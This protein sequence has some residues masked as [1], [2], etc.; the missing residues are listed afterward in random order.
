MKL[1]ALILAAG[2]SRR[3]GADNK[4]LASLGGEAVIRQTVTVVR[5]AGI[6]DIVAVTGPH[7]D[8]IEAVLHDL[9]VRCVRCSDDLDG[10]GYSI[11]AG[12]GALVADIDG[13]VIVP[14]DMPLLSAAS[15]RMLLSAFGAQGGRRIVHATDAMGAQ[16]NPVIWPRA[17]FAE[18]TALRGS[19]GAKALIRNAVAVRIPDRELL[20]I[21]TAADFATAREAIGKTSSLD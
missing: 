9:P 2:R 6:S 18:L 13:V 1:A 8:A 15:V 17:M 3:F 20:D 12:A 7:G 16:R 14:G 4:L 5:R 11:A 10:M 19:E 21:D